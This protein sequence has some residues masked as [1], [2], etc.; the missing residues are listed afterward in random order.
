MNYSLLESLAPIT[1]TPNI[2]DVADYFEKPWVDH[3]PVW[4]SQYFL[5]I[6]GREHYGR[7][8]STFVGIGALMLHLDFSNEEKETLLIRYVQLGIDLYG[9]MEDGGDQNWLGNGGFGSGRKWPILFAGVILNDS[10]MMNV[11]QRTEVSFGEDEQTFYVSQAEIDI[12]NNDEIWRPDNRSGPAEPYTVVDIGLPEWGVFHASQPVQDNRAWVSDPYRRCCTANSW[13]GFVLAA[14]IMGLKD[15]WNNDSLFDYQDRYM[16]IE[17][18]GEYTRDW[19][20]GFLEN[21]WDTY[22]ANYG[23]AFEPVNFIV[24]QVGSDQVDLAWEANPANTPVTGYRI[25]RSSDGGES[26]SQIAELAG[27]SY[28]DIGLL[29]ETNYN[30]QLRAYDANGESYPAVVSAVTTVGG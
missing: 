22:R 26:Y 30:Y 1:S 27:T 24:S 10:D 5:E 12:T 7:E 19:S 18:Y 28:S 25:Y 21:M 4:L 2:Q 17:P 14:H 20:G 3:I 9:V 11:G 15:S 6:N 16:S 23:P 13:S 29:P 8:I